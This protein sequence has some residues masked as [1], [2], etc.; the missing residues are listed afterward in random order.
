MTEVTSA[1]S[2]RPSCP[3]AFALKA[4]ALNYVENSGEAI[5][6]AQYATHLTTVH[7]P[8]FSTILASAFYGSG[9]HEDAISAA[10]AAIELRA[11]DVDPHLVLAAS[12]MA[13]GRPEQARSATEKVV[14]LAPNFNLAEFGETQPYKEQK[15]LDRLLDQLRSAGLQ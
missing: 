9:R 7:P 15:H 13:M 6:F 3:A 10:H 11:T 4:A 12:N 2:D 14:E 1:I 5:E 8:M